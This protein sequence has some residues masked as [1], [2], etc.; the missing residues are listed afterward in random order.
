MNLHVKLL[1]FALF[2]ATITFAS[3]N[4]A[5]F[6]DI[7]SDNEL[8]TTRVARR[9][10]RRL[11][12]IA[13][14]RE[15]SKLL[16][17]DLK[18]S[19]CKNSAESA[20]WDKRHLTSSAREKRIAAFREAPA[21]LKKKLLQ[22]AKRHVGKIH[23]RRKLHSARVDARAASLPDDSDYDDSDR[24]CTDDDELDPECC[25]CW[26]ALWATSVICNFIENCQVKKI[27]AQANAE[28]YAALDDA[29]DDATQDLNAQI[30]AL[31]C[32]IAALDDDLEEIEEAS[33]EV[34]AR[35]TISSFCKKYVLPKL[36]MPIR[37]R[38]AA[39]A[40]TAQYGDVLSK[41]ENIS[42]H[43]EKSRTKTM[44]KETAAASFTPTQKR[45]FLN[46]ASSHRIRNFT[47]SFKQQR[48]GARLKKEQLQ[49]SMIDAVS[50]PA[51]PDDTYDAPTTTT[52]FNTWL[53][54]L[55]ADD[56]ARLEAGS[57]EELVWAFFEYELSQQYV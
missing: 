19:I 16:A 27:I 35:S 15:D 49:A 11:K 5:A 12:D 4:A 37:E 24:S 46:E 43:K 32:E 56:I 53:E 18:R 6:T 8:A 29:L 38:L 51:D 31:D 25:E 42:F 52:R 44:R 3:L 13:A 47:Q 57:D 17:L 55:K 20:D 45:V 10:E 14:H 22:A 34:Y 40:F 41:L 23:E 7:D 36:L 28:T 2:A 48:N 39:K 26:Q 54:T 33:D 21:S 50:A 30:N 9:T 1:R